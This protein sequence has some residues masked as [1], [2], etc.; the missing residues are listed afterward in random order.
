MKSLFIIINYF[1]IIYFSVAKEYNIESH[2]KMILV[3]EHA[4]SKNDNLKIVKLE[5]TFK[6]STGNFGLFN[7]IVTINTEKKKIK[8][9]R[10][11]NEFTYKDDIKAYNVAKRSN[12]ELE[13]GVGI[14][15][16]NYASSNLK[17]LIN[18]ECIYSI[19]YFGDHYLCIAKCDV[20]DEAINELKNLNQ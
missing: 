9:L 6:D 2:G 1:F 14:W 20:T 17:S 16:Y 7:S 3:K 15:N 10:A 4:Y 13:Q 19:K 11:S 12:E 8:S 5:G 18:S